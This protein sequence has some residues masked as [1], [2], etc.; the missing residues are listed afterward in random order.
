MIV[1]LPAMISGVCPVDGPERSTIV[2][3]D[4]LVARQVIHD[5]PVVGVRMGPVR[6]SV[7]EPKGMAELVDH[8]PVYPVDSSAF[9]GFFVVQSGIGSPFVSPMQW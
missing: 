3:L 1:P 2:V 4:A 8:D 6:V 5:T 7:S 9:I